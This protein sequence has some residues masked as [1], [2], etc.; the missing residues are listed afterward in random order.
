MAQRRIEHDPQHQRTQGEAGHDEVVE[1]H[2]AH[3]PVE[4]RQMQGVARKPGQAVVA[5]CHRLPA[6]GDEIEHLAD[7]NRDHGEVNAAPPH[8]DGRKHRGDDA[9][10]QGAPQQRQQHVVGHVLEHESHAV[11]A[12]AEVGSVAERQSAGVSEQQVQAHRGQAVNQH[13]RGDVVVA[14]YVMQPR[15]CAEKHQGQDARAQMLFEIDGLHDGC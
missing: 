4:T 9:A 2:R 15:W 7:G 1:A 8:R 12:Q 3:R 14:T 13:P 11:A 5:P 6:N 10:E